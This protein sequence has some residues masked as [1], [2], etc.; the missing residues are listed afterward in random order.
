MLKQF[1]ITMLSIATILSITACQA[2]VGHFPTPTPEL[3]DLPTQMST[4]KA[5]P[6]VTPLCF[7]PLDLTPISFT[8]DN[9][10]LAIRT[11]S[12]VQ[13]F[14]LETIK[15]EDFIQAPQN[16]VSATLSPNGQILAWS[17]EDHSIQLIQVSDGQPLK[18]LKGHTDI[19]FKL[20]FSPNSEKLFSASHDG[21]VRVWDSKGDPLE[22]IETGGEVLGIGVSSDGTRLATIPFDGPVEVWDLMSYKKILALGGTGGFDTSDAAFSPDGEYLAAD[23]ATG[24]FLWRI[25]DGESLWDKVMNGLA[26]TF[27]PDGRFLAYAITDDQN[28]VILSSPDGTQVIRSLTGMQGPVWELIFSPDSSMLAATDGIE[29]RIWQVEDGKLLYVGKSSCS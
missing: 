13:I 14:N 12:G 10:M 7:T 28:R 4:E 6:S 3:I 16:I 2:N 20:R 11:N 23:L 5:I 19:V 26:I 29:I 1:L 17:F 24:L 27:S 25:S 15:E 18:T 21:T 9:K 8:P 22:V